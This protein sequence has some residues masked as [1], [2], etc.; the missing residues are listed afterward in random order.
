[1]ISVEIIY[2][3]AT[4][5]ALSVI[6]GFVD[7]RWSR[8][9]VKGMIVQGVLFGFV[10]ILGMMHPLVFGPGLIFD[11]RSVVVS[12]CGLFFGP[13]SVTI[14]ALMAVAYRIAEGGVGMIT[15][16]LVTAASA[17]IGVL[18]YYHRMKTGVRVSSKYLLVIGVI[19]HIVMLALI[20]TL[21]FG[22]AISILQDIGIPIIISYPLAT[23]L[24]GKIL[25]GQEENLRSFNKLKESEAR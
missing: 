13:L 7:Q 3:L 19:V 17:I 2:N 12:L 24:I 1:M 16:V 15:G 25:S 8:Y 14:A 4:L 21:P 23:V 5:V 22:L 6:S 10:A 11:G 18:F 9:T 20:F